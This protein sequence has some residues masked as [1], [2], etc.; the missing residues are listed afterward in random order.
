MHRAGLGRLMHPAAG[1]TG[2]KTFYMSIDG[3]R[4]S[5]SVGRAV[6]L[7]FHGWPDAPS[8]EAQHINLD[9]TDDRAENLQWGYKNSNKRGGHK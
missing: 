4:E 8:M 5:I 2:Q 7:A 3:D 9:L 1:P 6:A